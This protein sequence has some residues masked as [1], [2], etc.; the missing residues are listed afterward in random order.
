[1]LPV[2][3]LELA[4]REPSGEDEL[5][6]VESESAALPALLEL[7][8]RVVTTDAGGPVAWS[9][10]PA[11]DLGAVALEIRRAW[12]GSSIHTDTACPAQGCGERIDV[13]FT[14]GEY[15][16]HHRP[17]RARGAVPAGDGW[18][19]L[20]GTSVRFRI[21]TVGDVTAVPLDRAAPALTERCVESAGTLSAALARRV[22]RAMSVLAPSLD[23]L[24]GGACPE[25]GHEVALRFDPIGYTLAELRNAFSGIHAETHALASAYGW[26]EAAI[27]ALPRSRRRRYAS[28]VAQD[29]VVA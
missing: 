5:L 18:W 17:R 14:V 25:C 13:G 21:P 28:L 9:E 8:R 2:S 23:G 16:D 6:V 7:A 12:I 4:V 11:T 3:R 20:P 19:A 29:R 1:V 15:V 27:L 26:P 10:L 24:L 22:D